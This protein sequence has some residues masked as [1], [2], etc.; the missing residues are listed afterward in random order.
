MVNKKLSI[1]LFLT[2]PFFSFSQS[3]DSLS[4]LI[5]EI[6]RGKNDSVR[7]AA[8][9]KFIT[10]FEKL[11]SQSGS[12]SRN[13]DS[14]KNVSVQT[15]SDSS[16]RIFTWVVPH[17]DGQEYNFFGFVQLH[18]AKSDTM[19]RLYDS[20]AVIQKPES[21]KLRAD[22][23]LG[24]VYYDIIPIESAGKKYYT[25]LGWKGK[26]QEHTLKIIDVLSVN[27]NQLKFGFPIFKTGSVYRNRMV[28]TYNSQASMTLHF[29]KKFNGIVFDHLAADKNNP[30]L[31]TG[32]DG[33]YDA[34]KLKKGKWILYTDVDVRTKW[35]PSETLPEPPPVEK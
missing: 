28:F 14:L 27:N 23:W 1:L 35:D 13:Y 17:F 2:I 16:F 29:N 4:T 19:I 12:F 15:A 7:F 26:N 21:E 10:Y 11:L 8:N 20:T 34:F 32:P 33:T 18:S 6:Q 5:K 31:I 25:L 24:A 22:R 30:S 3:N 9:E